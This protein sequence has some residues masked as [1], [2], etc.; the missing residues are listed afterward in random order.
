[1]EA[2]IWGVPAIAVSLDVK[3][4]FEGLIDCSQ[5]AQIASR[6]TQTVYTQH[7]PAGI[8]LN[9]NIPHQPFERIRGIRM[10]RQGMRV[11][12]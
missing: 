5:A 4:G 11:Y 6:I 1:M 2:A 3:A 7:L 12:R 8:L 10:T 9:V